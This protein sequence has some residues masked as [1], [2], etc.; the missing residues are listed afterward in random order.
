MRAPPKVAYGRPRPPATVAVMVKSR[1][2][3]PRVGPKVPT[4]SA[5]TNPANPAMAPA[6]AQVCMMIRRAGMPLTCASA[7]SWEI[8]RTAL[9]N[10]VRCSSR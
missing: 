9:P 5:S 7:R 8:A 2:L 10:R 4:V 1:K 6:S 3:K